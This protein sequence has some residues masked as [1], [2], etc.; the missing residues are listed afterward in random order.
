[1]HPAL[2]AAAEAAAVPLD[3][4]TIAA[5]VSFFVPLLVSAITKRTASDGLKSVVNVVATAVVAVVALFTVPLPDG[6]TLSW[7]LIANTFL[8]SIMASLVGYKG[9]WKPTGIT[10][11]IEAKTANVGL[12][13]P[14]VAETKEGI[15]ED[16]VEGDIHP[17]A[18]PADFPYDTVHDDPYSQAVDWDSIPAVDDTPDRTTR[19]PDMVPDEAHTEYLESVE[20]KLTE[21]GDGP[22]GEAFRA[23]QKDG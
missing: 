9:V 8:G 5:L 6:V 7:T 22:E 12:S 11:T 14:P 13:S 1:M 15:A 16:V 20:S 21:I 3:T 19:E 4:V 23:E 2:V 17:E 10:T 18:M